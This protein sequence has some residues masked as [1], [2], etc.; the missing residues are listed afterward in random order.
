M[1]GGG[2]RTHLGLWIERIAHANR[3]GERQE[4]LEERIGDLLLQQQPRSRDASLPLIVEDRE[5]RA[6]HGG[7]ERGVVEDD[8]G[9]LAAEFELH[10]LQISR[11]S[12]HDFAAG[13]GGAGEGNLVDAFVLGKVLA[14]GVSVARHDVDDAGRKADLGHQLG[15]AQRA[16][17]RQFGLLQHD[18]IACRQ[19]GPIFQLVKSSG[20]FQGTMAPTTPSGSRVT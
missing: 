8:V 19:R 15:D 17:R 13:N 6:A 9:A 12:L 3:F 1:A 20:K 11:R 2:E 7:I 16:E 4:L 18:G 5:G 14:G 10:A